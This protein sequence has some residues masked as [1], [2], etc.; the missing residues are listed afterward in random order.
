VREFARDIQRG[1]RPGL[2]FLHSLLP[3]HPWEY[4]PDGKSYASNLGAQPGLV[5][6]RWV[7]DPELAIQAQQRHLLQVGFADLALGRV[8]DRLERTELYDDALVVVVADHG[9]SFRPHGERRRVN[10][11]DLEDIA[12]VPFFLK[13]P[14]QRAGE[15]VDA[16]VRTVDVLPTIADVLG[17]VVPWRTDGRSALG[18]PPGAYP[19]VVVETASGDQVV[20][21]FGDLVARRAAALE[22]QVDLFGQGDDQPGLY[23]I[24]PRPELLGRTVDGLAL[25]TAAG[26]PAFRSYGETTYDPDSPVAPVRVT[27]RIE[28]APAGEDVAI[29]V[30]GRIVAVTR[31]FELGGDVLVSAVVPESAF[32]PGQ[33]A[34]RVYIVEGAGEDA[35]LRELAPAG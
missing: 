14:G 26:G 19:D 29:A 25:T 17:I 27:G 32:R 34:V 2:F 11:E 10:A 31:S 28:G 4:L 20:G 22:R 15:V 13:A 33:N 16:H 18:R 3:H 6:E 1:D 9:V 7:G 23:G 24:G 35:T 8:L 21:T 30:N 12:F 5:D